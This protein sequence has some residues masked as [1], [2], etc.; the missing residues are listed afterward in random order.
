MY[1]KERYIDSIAVK[2]VQ[3]LFLLLVQFYSLLYFLFADSEGTET[4]DKY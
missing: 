1:I 3:L 2:D 4:I